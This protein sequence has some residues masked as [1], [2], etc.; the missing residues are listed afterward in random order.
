MP[1]VYIPTAFTLVEI[2][3]FVFSVLGISWQNIRQK[4][5]KVVGE[6]A[7]KAMETGF[8]IVVTLVTQGPA[9]AWDKIKEQLGNLKDTVI[10][11]I[12]DFVV[13]TVV[14]KAIPKLL[15]MF[16]PGAGFISAIISIYDTVMVFVNKISQIVQVVTGFIDSIVAIAGGQITAAANKV[17]QALANVLSLAINFLAGFVGLGKVADK[18]MGVIGKVRATI[19]RALDALINWIVNTAKRLFARVFGRRED[20]GVGGDVK[21]KAERALAPKLSSIGGDGSGV[22]SA[23]NEVHGQL[24]GE[25]LKQLHVVPTA[26]AD[27]FEVH[28]VA[29]PG[30]KVGFIKT[31][32]KLRISDLW[33]GFPKTALT[34]TFN[35]RELGRWDSR[36][37]VHAEERFITEYLKPNW[38]DWMKKPQPISPCVV[39]MRI[40]RSPCG[41]PT[42]DEP[43]NRNC[44]GFIVETT[45]WA[46]QV[47]AKYGK[48]VEFRIFAAS[49][50]RGA[51][52]EEE[53]EPATQAEI[54]IHELLAAGVK[55]E[56]W[57]IVEALEKK[58][59][60]N[61]NA[62]ARRQGV[63]ENLK[64]KATE[65]KIFL[66]RIKGAKV[67]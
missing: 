35:S 67:G 56:A 6:P 43:T 12:T 29:S 55:I 57:D 18:V 25:G 10:N 65:I 11:G 13:D 53:G 42:P 16:I 3:K 7:V 1:G 49:L 36:N 58:G 63:K 22:Q 44:A 28:A 39:E 5:V 24:R 34:A 15:S 52:D 14:K 41:R 26:Y 66:D 17:E 21:Q 8:D 31:H 64:K 2:V 30:T 51:S 47:A 38:E 27:E 37:R 60:R 59:V 23:L 50:Y 45:R 40:T 4:L 46:Q 48:V 32:L 20:T 33:L 54:A 61:I 62:A 9:A 19:D